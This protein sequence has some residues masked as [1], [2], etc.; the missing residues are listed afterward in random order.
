MS[1][2]HCNCFNNG[3]FDEYKQ[4]NSIAFPALSPNAKR[5][6]AKTMHVRKGVFYSERKQ[7]LIP[8]KLKDS[9]IPLEFKTFVS[10]LKKTVI[11]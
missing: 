9:A 11:K 4:I 5:E 6:L 1:L 10:K 7:S 8:C 3:T 2:Q